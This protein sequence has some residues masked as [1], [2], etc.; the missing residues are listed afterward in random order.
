M[1][2]AY[3]RRFN[4]YR[5]SR[6]DLELYRLSRIEEHLPACRVPEE[7]RKQQLGNLPTIPTITSSYKRK[8][9]ELQNLGRSL[10]SSVDL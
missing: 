7:V 9:K 10:P 6:W 1:G 5:D 8:G 3:C 4:G 2:T